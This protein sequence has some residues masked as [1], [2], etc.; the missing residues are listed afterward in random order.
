MLKK[1]HAVAGWLLAPAASVADAARRSM[2]HR[3][4]RRDRSDGIRR[5]AALILSGDECT[6]A[7][8]LAS[9]VRRREDRVTSMH[10]SV[11]AAAMSTQW[12]HLTA[13]A[14]AAMEL[15]MT[16]VLVTAIKQLR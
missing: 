8:V 10:A 5:R 6:C 16:I 13:A 9:F 12:L 4:R 14:P 3:G 11:S 7:G 2:L 15:D 1:P